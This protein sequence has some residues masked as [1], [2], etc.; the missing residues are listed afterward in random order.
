MLLGELIGSGRTADVHALD[1]HR[2]LRRYRDGRDAAEEA[3]VMAYLGT[4]GYPVPAVHPGAPTPADLILE[5]LTGP[6]LFAS[7]L[8][9]DTPIP[10]GGRLLA[11]LLTR[12]H[13][14]PPRHADPILHLDLHPENVLLTPRGPVV[15]D[16]HDSAEGPPGYDLAVSA[17]ILAEV[18]V[19]DSPIAG[20]SAALLTALLDA[21]GPTAAT[22]PTHLPHAHARRAANPTLRPGEHEAVDAALSLLHRQ[23]QISL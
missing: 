14:V 22:I 3:A 11:D 6:T 2:V 13:A 19:A 17:M 15:I 12:L 7:L 4:H 5:R 16:W 9:G 21:L 10:A 20:P 23:P 8:A 1:D 18:A